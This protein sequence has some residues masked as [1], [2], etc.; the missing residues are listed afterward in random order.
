MVS[1]EDYEDLLKKGNLHKAVSLKGTFNYPH[2]GT[3]LE[4]NKR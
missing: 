4:W 3:H 2:D 1:K